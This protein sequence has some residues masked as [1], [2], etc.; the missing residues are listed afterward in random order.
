MILPALNQV[1]N[2]SKTEID[3]IDVPNAVQTEI[4]VTNLV[5]IPLSNTD[6]FPVLL[7]N[8]VLGGGA[9]SRL[10][11]NLREKHGF[12]YGCY[13][14]VEAGRFQTM[15]RAQASVRNDK[16]DSAVSEILSE[17]NHIRDEKI[18]PEELQN[19]KALYNGNFALGMEDPARTASFASN[20]LIQ[21]LPKDFYRTYLQKINSVSADDV[22]RVAQK[23]FNHDNT[24]VVVVGKSETIQAGLA[25]L[26]YSLK[27]YDRFAMPAAA[28]AAVAA[29]VK[30]SDIIDKYVTAI[31]G[32]EELKKISS[33]NI[34]GNGGCPGHEHEHDRK[35]ND[36]QP[37]TNGDGYGY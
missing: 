37:R 28:K 17:I 26:P 1:L 4:T 30:A 9:Q 15:F 27:M 13:S 34:T 23:Y 18:T 36:T 22:Q 35:E 12:T 8:Q 25:K 3:L 11:M 16:V 6:Y 2:P 5:S 31:G 10:F 32:N 14:S 29:N 24:R 7:A 19:A 33:L 21:G 20:I